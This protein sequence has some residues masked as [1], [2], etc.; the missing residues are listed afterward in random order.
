MQ[1]FLWFLGSFL[2]FLIIDLTWLGLIAVNFYNSRL[3][4]LKA[5]EINW[6]AGIL[7]YILFVIGLMYFVVYPAILEKDIKMAALNGAL[8]G[9]FAYMTYDLTNLAVIK[10]WPLDMSIVDILWGTVLGCAVCTI[11]YV[12]GSKLL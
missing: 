1:Y 3:K 4:D 11:S 12:L 2:S 7:F 5:T 6:S 9:F 8:L 10:N